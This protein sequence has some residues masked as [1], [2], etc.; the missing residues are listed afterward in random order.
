MSF[1]FAVPETIA[2]AASSLTGLGSAVSAA[3]AAASA[4]TTAVV[5]AGVDEVSGAI[6][7]LFGGYG[8]QFQALSA[9]AAAFH[10][11]FV[12]SLT[13]GA[14]AYV[15]AEAASINPLQALQTVEHDVV[16]QSTRPF[17]SGS[18]LRARRDA[19]ACSPLPRMRSASSSVLVRSRC[20]A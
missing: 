19:T 8:Q 14:G 12:Q 18:K 9:Q 2:D 10:S 17:G 11:Q 15:A 16:G 5:A 4:H 7:V 13:A 1:V 6:A 3:N 20:Q